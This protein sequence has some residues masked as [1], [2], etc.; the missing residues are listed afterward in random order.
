M[1]F[2]RSREALRELLSNQYSPVEIAIALSLYGYNV[3]AVERAKRIYD[4][5][6]GH[7]AEMDELVSYMINYG[8]APTALPFPSAEVYVQHA[9]ERYGEE[10]KDRV[11][12][13]R[14]V[15]SN[16]EKR[17]QEIADYEANP[18]RVAGSKVPWTIRKENS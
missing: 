12:V 10:A 8:C 14:N 7:C 18:S 16:I 3:S 6:E 15:Q 2:L 9:L 11:R 4:H 17:N 5:F 1:D 13:E